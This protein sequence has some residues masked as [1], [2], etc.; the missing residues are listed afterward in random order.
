MKKKIMAIT[1]TVLFLFTTAGMSFAAQTASDSGNDELVT[2][3]INLIAG[4]ADNSDNALGGTEAGSLDGLTDILSGIADI[5]SG[6]GDYTEGVEGLSDLSDLF[7]GLADSASGTAD[8]A[9]G[10]G[11]DLSDLFSGL[12]DIAGDAT[13]GEIADG[14]LGDLEDLLSGLMDSGTEEIDFTEPAVEEIDYDENGIPVLYWD[15]V[16]AEAEDLGLSGEYVLFDE[17]GMEMWVPDAMVPAE[18]PEDQEGAETYVGFFVTAEEDSFVSVQYIPS[19]ITLEDYRQIVESLEEDIEGPEEYIINDQPFLLYYV[20][21]TDS[22]CMSTV[23][24][25]MGLVEFI[26]AP[27]GDGDFSVYAD[28]MGVSIRPVQ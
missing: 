20:S 2:G 3:I 12:M 27:L 11:S 9:E 19:D 21:S 24:D 15:D 22:M 28:F 26:F 13:D 14:D 8:N 10:A 18:V 6:S 7:S 25:G 4:L 17:I 5:A 1:V 16:K 23:L